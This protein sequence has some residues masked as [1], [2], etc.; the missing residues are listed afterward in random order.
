MKFDVFSSAEID[1][2]VFRFVTL[3]SILRYKRRI[4]LNEYASISIQSR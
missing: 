2:V 4:L 3:C 1:I